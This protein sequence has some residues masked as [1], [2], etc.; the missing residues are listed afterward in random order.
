MVRIIAMSLNVVSSAL[1]TPRD[2]LMV[3]ILD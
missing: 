2:M 3:E 1:E